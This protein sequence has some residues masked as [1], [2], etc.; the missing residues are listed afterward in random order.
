MLKRVYIAG[1]IRKGDLAENIKQS[2]VAVRALM[3]AGIAYYNP[4]WSCYAGGCTRWRFDSERGEPKV[5]GAART[6]AH[7]P[8]IAFENWMEND[9]SWISVCDAVLRLPGESTGADLETKFATERGIPVFTNVE[10]LIA[11]L[12]PP[13]EINVPDT[14]IRSMKIGDTCSVYLSPLESRAQLPI[15]GKYRN[16][17]NGREYKVVDRWEGDYETVPGRVL[18]W[19]YNER[20]RTFARLKQMV[21]GILG[22]T[23][24]AIKAERIK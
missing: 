18:E 14:N 24:V 12:R 8:E 2:D 3:G 20:Y 6:D 13:I 23:V 16:V 4:M 22:S 7:W 17:A 19:A 15:G 21:E 10:E 9:Y 1:P 11:F 5:I